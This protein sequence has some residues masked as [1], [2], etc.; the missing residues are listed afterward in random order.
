MCNIASGADGWKQDIRPPESSAL[1]EPS[2]KRHAFRSLPSLNALPPENQYWSVA[3]W[4]PRSVTYSIPTIFRDSGRTVEVVQY[5]RSLHRL[6]AVRRANTEE[7]W[8][9][10]FGGRLAWRGSQRDAC[11]TWGPAP[12]ILDMDLPVVATYVLILKLEI[13]DHAR[14]GSH[15]DDSRRGVIIVVRAS[16]QIGC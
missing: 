1:S 13:E 12:Q 9:F 16:K 10:V 3:E 14:T 8:A 2:P 4:P 7:W 15:D 5:G 11:P 6:C